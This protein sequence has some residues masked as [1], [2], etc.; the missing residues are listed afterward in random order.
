MGELGWFGEIVAGADFA[1][2]IVAIEEEPDEPDEGE[3][4]KEVG[5]EGEA[6]NEDAEQDGD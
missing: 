1:I 3:E 5:A 4:A 2:M 6:A